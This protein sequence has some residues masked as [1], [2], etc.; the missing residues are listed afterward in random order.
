[1]GWVTWALLVAAWVLVYAAART[2][3]PGFAR[4]WLGLGGVALAVVAFFWRHL[5][6]DDA[7][8]PAGGGDLA[9]FIYPM[10]DFAARRFQEG[11]VPLWNPY[12]YGGAPFA[13]DI[14]SGVFYPINWLFFLLVGRVDY[15]DVML[16]S[17]FHVFLAGAAMYLCLRS[18][19]RSVRPRRWDGSLPPAAALTGAIAYMFSDL[20]LVHLGNLNLI[21]VAA[22][23]PLVFLFFR[24][25]CTR[26]LSPRWGDAALAGV[27]L[28][29]AALAGHV[30]IFLYV[31]LLLA[32]YAAFRMIGSP[33]GAA[34]SS[35]TRAQLSPLAVLLVTLVIGG[36]LAAPL[37][38]PALEMSGR[39]IRSELDYRE[40]SAYSLPPAK[41]IGLLVPGFFERDPSL[42]W[43]PWDRVE[44]G[45]LGVL[46]LLLAGLGAALSR[47]R[48]NRFWLALAGLALFVAL[49]G[50]AIVHGWLYAAFPG[51]ARLRAP[52]RIIV[53][54]DFALAALAAQ[55]VAV[56][57]GPLSPDPRRAWRGFWRAAPWLFAGTVLLTA[58]LTYYALLIGQEKDPGLFVRYARAANGLLLFLVFLGA[59]LALLALRRARL[60]RGT[61]FGLL[62]ALLVL[63]DLSSTGA[64][65]DLASDPPTSGYEHPAIVEF[66][67]R[68]P[69]LF[70]IDTRTDVWHLW[71]PDL[72][73]LHDIFDV[74]GVVNPLTLADYDRYWE[75][76]GSRSSPLYDFLNARYVIARKDVDLDWDKFAPVFDGDPDLNVYL[77]RRA[78][79]RA[80]VVYSATAA[81]NQRAAFDAIHQPGFDPSREVVVEGGVSLSASEPVSGSVGLIA[82]GSNG[83]EWQVE[84]SAPGYLVLSE[85]YYPGWV[86]T[87]DGQPAEVLRA[88]FAFRAVPIEPGTHKVAL[89]FRP[90]SLYT[91]LALGGVGAVLCLALLLTSRR[92]ESTIHERVTP[93]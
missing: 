15:R 63:I 86:A 3:Q 71:Q 49:G 73:L 43:G 25:A 4:D 35:L 93:Q 64:Y 75:N 78:L 50:H 52:A 92:R 33:P 5:F 81:P 58:P 29:V 21:A 14:Q 41:L 1:M 23:L 89:A 42:H 8:T 84:A 51:F 47:R 11:V 67:K 45:Y 12:L 32:A 26:G 19:H 18:L 31:V 57:M 72:P 40:A 28:A 90:R 74:W 83:M 87:V 46:S 77:N 34:R 30:Q 70:R 80:F 68:D 61:T 24:R 66:L 79:P 56:L 44:I 2:R 59:G 65:L 36:L 85:T 9:S 16:W 6:T 55:G 91:G 69:E 17:F 20:F 48:L 37:L 82:Y 10:Y 7:W 27:F 54:L 22:W 76:M 60:L 38:L 62:A 39:A 13:A 88:N 53:L